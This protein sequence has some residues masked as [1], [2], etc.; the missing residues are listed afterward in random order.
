MRNVPY[1]VCGKQLSCC[2]LLSVHAGIA[3]TVAMLGPNFV[4]AD[5]DPCIT[6]QVVDLISSFY[7]MHS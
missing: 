1:R 4:L 2:A 5:I 7:A 6:I 3:I